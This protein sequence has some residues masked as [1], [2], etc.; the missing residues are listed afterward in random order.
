MLCVHM[1]IGHLVWPSKAFKNILQ[2][3]YEMCV[4]EM[5]VITKTVQLWPKL[6]IILMENR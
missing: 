5:G 2:L 6:P 3:L 4:L 1:E